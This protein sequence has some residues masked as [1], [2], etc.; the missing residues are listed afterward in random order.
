MRQLKND[1]IRYL[2]DGGAMLGW[3]SAVFVIVIA[4]GAVLYGFSNGNTDMSASRNPANLTAPMAA[5]PPVVPMPANREP[6]GD[7]G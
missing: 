1:D 6:A 5:N 3:I 4:A 7:K 2:R